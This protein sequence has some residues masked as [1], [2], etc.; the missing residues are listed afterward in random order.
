MLATTL[1][2]HPQIRMFG[3]L[4]HPVTVERSGPHAIVDR[5]GRKRFFNPAKEDAIHFLQNEVWTASALKKNAVGFKLF[6]DYLKS[7]ATDRL[8][9]RIVEMFPEVRLVTIWRENLLDC[10]ISR[11]VARASG[12]W[13]ESA[14]SLPGDTPAAVVSISPTEAEAFFN[15]YSEVKWFLDSLSNQVPSF[16]VDYDALSENFESVSEGL[17]E[18]L[19]LKCVP[20]HQALRKQASFSQSQYVENWSELRSHFIHSKYHHFFVS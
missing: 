1:D 3:E 14:K 5:L 20:V 18:F 10:L 4:F 6:G 11:Q 12:K 16:A 2:Q 9:M 15:G 19:G 8:F 7:P 17:F 13:M